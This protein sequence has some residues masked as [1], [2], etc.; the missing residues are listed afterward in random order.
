MVENDNSKLFVVYSLSE[1]SE[2]FS[3]ILFYEVSPYM[4]ET[5]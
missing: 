5:A 1:A 2:I 4:T 3:F